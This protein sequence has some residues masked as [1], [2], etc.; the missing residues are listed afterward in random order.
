VEILTDMCA[1]EQNIPMPAST[2]F[3][4]IHMNF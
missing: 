3:R 4:G 2:I 1:N